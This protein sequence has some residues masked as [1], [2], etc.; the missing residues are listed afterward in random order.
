MMASSSSIIY[1]RFFLCLAIAISSSRCN[2]FVFLLV[3]LLLLLLLLLLLFV[4]E[5]A[6]KGMLNVIY[7]YVYN[8]N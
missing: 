1:E 7:S 8:D 6:T 5:V 4:A 2:R 3:A